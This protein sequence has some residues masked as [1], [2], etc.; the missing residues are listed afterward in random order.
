MLGAS[1]SRNSMLL[2]LFAIVSTAIIS[3]TFLQ[4]SEQI[5]AN[6]RHAEEQALFDIA[7]KSRHNNIM[8]DDFVA[9]SDDQLLSLRKQ[10]KI[11]IAKQ[12]NIPVAV[13]IPAT[14]R[15]GYTGDIDL[16]VGINTDGTVSGV[17]VLS[18]R[19]TPGPGDAVDRK[20]SDWVEGFNGKSLNN[21]NIERWKVKKDKG[22]FDQFTGATI[23]PR[24]VT[25][26]VLQA[27]RYFEQHQQNIFQAQKTDK[28]TIT[29]PQTEEVI[30]HG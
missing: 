11:Y 16:I 10:K 12:N 5:S 21:P 29:P 28:Q 23:T 9:V 1:I 20:K 17:R 26:A 19:E 6:I 18:H 4:T 30:H 13:I 7:P 25:K 3:A 27:L 24:A 2:G 22:V 14:A 15:D 8:L